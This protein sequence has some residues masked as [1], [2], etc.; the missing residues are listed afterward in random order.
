[1]DAGR[2]DRHSLAG[3]PQS[4]IRLGLHGCAFSITLW[5]Q[6]MEV[7]T[8]TSVL[9]TLARLRREL[10]GELEKLV[11]KRS[12]L[13]LEPELDVMIESTRRQ[14]E[15]VQ[16]TE[17]QLAAQASAQ[18]QPAAEEGGPGESTQIRSLAKLR[19]IIQLV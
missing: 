1:L 17:E 6:I 8:L 15:L 12:E 10:Q 19:D 3:K 2:A 16:T 13:E 4:P 11:E 7:P 18:A 5:L 14:L 9:E